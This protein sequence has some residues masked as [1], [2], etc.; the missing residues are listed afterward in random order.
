MAAPRRDCVFINCPFDED[1]HPIFQAIVFTISSCGFVPRCALEHEDGGQARIER[2]YHLIETCGHGIHDVSRTEL[3]AANNLPRFNMPLELGVFLGVK[4]FGSRGQRDKRC[5]VLDRERYRFQK[6]ISDIAGQDIRA[7]QDEPREAIH[8]VRDWLRNSMQESNMPGGGH[9]WNRYQQF[10]AELQNLCEE[11]HLDRGHLVFN[12]YL[13]LVTT[14][15]RA[16]L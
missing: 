4:R 7:H 1:Y 11:A 9:I 14:W 10:M 5:L 6:F 3:D 2:I 13:Q 16:N 8:A 12:D 15:L